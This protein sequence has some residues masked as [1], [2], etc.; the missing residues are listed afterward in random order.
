MREFLLA[1]VP[2]KPNDS[3]AVGVLAAFL[4]GCDDAAPLH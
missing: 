2:R 4:V 1:T 3:K